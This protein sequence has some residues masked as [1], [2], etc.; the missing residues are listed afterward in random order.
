M[1]APHASPS[2]DPGPVALEH[3]VVLFDGVCNFCDGTVDFLMDRDPDRRLRFAALQS[4]IGGRLLRQFEIAGEP[5]ET[6]ILIEDGLAY[7][8]STAVLR[9]AR[10]LRSP[11]RFASWL[12][13][14]PE[15]VRDAIYSWIARNRYRWFGTRRSCRM[16][17]PE[18][19]ERFLT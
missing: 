18:D 5:L 15:G 6:L 11:W 16:P 9:S 3:P 7:T 13:A 19:R 8:R 1:I 10:Y 2:S 12:L 17:T 4:E 14:V